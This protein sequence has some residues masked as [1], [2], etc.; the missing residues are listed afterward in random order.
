[1]STIFR[2]IIVDDERP[3][4]KMLELLLS[5]YSRIEIVATF[6]DITLALENIV[7]KNI[8]LVFLDIDMPK[9]NGIEAAKKIMEMDS[10][11]DIVF[12]TAYQ[13][14]ALEAFEIKVLYLTLP[15]YISSVINFLMI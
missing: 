11:I 2:T 5:Q 14:F 1:V 15:S 4:L 3:A 10:T 13:H 12:V 7:N 6:T 8:D 9:I